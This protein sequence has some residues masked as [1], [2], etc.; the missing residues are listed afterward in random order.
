M[1]DWE[2]RLRM[3]RIAASTVFLVILVIQAVRLP[4]IAGSAAGQATKATDPVL[5][6]LDAT[7]ANVQATTTTGKNLVEMIS[8]D[9]Y[10]P[11]NPEGGL[12][13]DLYSMLE[14]S[15]A[16]S[17]TTEETLED[18]RAALIGGQD[19]RGVEHEGAIPA[20]TELL[21]SLKTTSDGFRQDLGA[22]TGV[23]TDA[24]QPLQA[25]LDSV[26]RFSD[27]LEQ[28]M[29]TGGD[30]AGAL[31]KLNQAVGDVNTLLENDD[32]QKILASSAETSQHLAAS[33]ESVDIALRPWRKK[34]NQLKMLLQK[35]AGMIKLVY[36]L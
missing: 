19:S 15:T 5:K 27:D 2:K 32:I 24:L 30:V 26:A 18:L 29:R 9:Y 36:Q 34:A 28:E 22:L 33:A 16:A 20:A 25:T 11:N 7:L 31:A 23:A 3:A 13:W 21:N 6:K 17:R 12:F 10:D 8:K 1:I 14:S 35:A 4:Q